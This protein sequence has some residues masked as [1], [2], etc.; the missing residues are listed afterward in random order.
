MTNG[1]GKHHEEERPVER[2]D[3]KKQPKKGEV[4]RTK[5]RAATNK[6]A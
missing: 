5:E 6:R 1:G 3:A 2:K 4:D